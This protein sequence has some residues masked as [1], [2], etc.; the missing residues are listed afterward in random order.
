AG[1]RLRKFVRRH[2]GPV[3]AAG[4]LVLALL[5]GVVGT[6]IGLVRADQ[7]RRV[8]GERAEGERRAKEAAEAKDAET[9]A[10]FSFVQ[11]RILAAARPE[12]QEGGLGREVT[13]RRAL[14]AALPALA[15]NFAKQPLTEA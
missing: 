3:L 6:A 2:R 9:Q 7:A 15:T 13:L 14:E 8:A 10:M 5:G 1:Y 12:G 11:S 4:L